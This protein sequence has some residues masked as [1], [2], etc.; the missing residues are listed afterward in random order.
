MLKRDPEWLPP[1]VEWD[2]RSISAEECDFAC[3]WEYSRTL[4]TF[5]D[6]PEAW[7]HHEHCFRISVFCMFSNGEKSPKPWTALSVKE[8]TTIR[9]CVHKPDAIMIRPIKEVIESSLRLTGGNHREV[10]EMLSRHPAH[11]LW[12]D[13]ALYGSEKVIK[14]FT[15]WARDEFEKCPRTLRGK[16]A[17]PPYNCL[18]WLAAYRIEKARR[19]RGFSF[20][21]TQECLIHHQRKSSLENYTDVLPIY[22]SH[23]AWSKALSD[24]E[25]ILRLHEADPFALAVKLL[26][27]AEWDVKNYPRCI[28]LLARAAKEKRKANRK[29]EPPD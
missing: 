29:T 11:V 18:K 12:A 15:A 19:K 22:A 17:T 26:D 23:G 2:F 1:R 4:S 8:R 3:F 7:I 10:L 28:E 6:N 5:T 20:E 16:A 25:R 14:G 13:F 24:A 27:P 9:R 21:E